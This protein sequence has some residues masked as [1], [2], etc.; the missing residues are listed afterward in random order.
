MSSAQ[1]A[2]NGDGTHG[3]TTAVVMMM[4]GGQ[5]GDDLDALLLRCGGDLG[6]IPGVDGGG[7]LPSVGSLVERRALCRFLGVKLVRTVPGSVDS[8]LTG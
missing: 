2:E 5:R 6:D 1:L 7:L 3:V 4:M 8:V